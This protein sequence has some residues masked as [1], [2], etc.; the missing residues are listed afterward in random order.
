VVEIEHLTLPSPT[1]A[2]GHH[3]IILI[4]MS[5]PFDRVCMRTA[6]RKRLIAGAV[7]LY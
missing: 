7:R 3:A 5:P 4:A 1:S 2:I 6:R